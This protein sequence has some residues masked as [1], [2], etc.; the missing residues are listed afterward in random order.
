MNKAFESPLASSSPEETW[1][2]E[3]RQQIGTEPAVHNRSGIDVRPLYTPKDLDG[4]D[5]QRDLG[6]PGQ[7]PFTRG[8]YPT[9]HR[10]RT[11][12]QRQLI[13]LGTPQDYNE[14]LRHLLEQGA[15]AISLLPCNSVFRGYDMDEVPVEL[16]GTCGTVIN[17]V[18]HM[19]QAL[20]GVDL[21]Q[22]SCAMNDP[23]P[24][25]LL[26]F[27]LVTAKRRQVPWSAI[28]GT[29]NQSDYLSHFIANHMFYRLANAGARRLLV[30]HIEF[31][32]RH[33]PKWNPMSVVGQHTQQAGATPAEAMAFT[34][35]AAIQNAED[36]IAHGMHPDDFLPR[37]TFF[38]DIS[39]SFFEEIAKFR[40]GRRIWARITRERLGA[41]DSRSWRF[42]FHGQTSG[43]DLT[44][45]Q[46]LNNI[47][48]VSVQA[49]AGIFGGLQ[50]LHTDAFDE[51][52]SCPTEAGARIAVATQNILKEEAHLT[53]VIDPLGGSYYIEAL[54]NEMEERI[55]AVMARIDAAGGMY[56]AVEAGLVQRMI[57]ESALRFQQTVESGEQTVVGVNKYQVGGESAQPAQPRPDANSMAALI[58]DFRRFKSRRSAAEV[59]RA[60]DDLARAAHDPSI[61]LFSR[62]I[63]A[64]E[65]GVTHGEIC[66]CL[67][68]EMG[69]GLPLVAV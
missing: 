48:R 59:G 4:T 35:S 15:T 20:A 49:M 67:R 26:A 8:I 25:T 6:Y 45:Q 24:F 53:D 21:A 61:N 22:I 66:A 39:I 51:A 30:D 10:G 46:P 56:Q 43:A 41:R 32:V 40:A 1:S 37:F 55:E 11:W 28:A 34:L 38:F 12:T 31:C 13:G 63:D 68:R 2:Q 23:T 60:L 52:I 64:A 33:L 47:S 57:G 44:R 19:D 27:L 69:F 58:D 36:C 7:A 18:D 5:Y 16:L 17:N 3:Y 14:R 42:K 29:S 65:A 62:V 54:T 9:M 50:S